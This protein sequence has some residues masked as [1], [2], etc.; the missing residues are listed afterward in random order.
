MLDNWSLNDSRETQLIRLIKFTKESDVDGLLEGLNSSSLVV[1]E[2]YNL[3]RRLVYKTDNDHTYF[4]EDNYKNLINVLAELNVKKSSLF[5]VELE[6][7][8]IDEL[9]ERNIKFYYKSFWSFVLSDLELLW[10]F[11]NGEDLYTYDTITRW[12]SDDQTDAHIEIYTDKYIG[13]DIVSSTDPLSLHPYSPIYFT[14]KSGLS[15][16]NDY[17]DD[18]PVLSPAI[19]AFYA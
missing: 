14:N 15:M 19:L 11:L 2:D 9:I 6:N 1:G 5:S 8:S 16:L 13:N 3:L 4:H 10:S 12:L 7:L 18:L 17:N